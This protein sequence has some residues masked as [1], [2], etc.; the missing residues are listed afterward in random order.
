MADGVLQPVSPSSDREVF[1]FILSSGLPSDVTEALV[2]KR[3]F[4]ASLL[5]AARA[6]SAPFGKVRFFS[7][8]LATAAESKSSL[9]FADFRGGDADTLRFPARLLRCAAALAVRARASSRLFVFRCLT[10]CV[11]CLFS[12]NSTLPCANDE[13]WRESWAG[14]AEVEDKRTWPGTGAGLVRQLIDKRS[15]VPLECILF[16]NDWELLLLGLIS[17][18]WKMAFCPWEARRTVGLRAADVL[19]SGGFTGQVLPSDPELSSIDTA[20][21]FFKPLQSSK[22]QFSLRSDI[23]RLATSRAE[24]P[25]TF[26]LEFS[27]LTTA[28]NRARMPRSSSPFDSTAPALSAPTGFEC[29]SV[30]CVASHAR[31]ASSGDA[32]LDFP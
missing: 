19:Q 7:E 20:G 26:L 24:K 17:R 13:N 12:P 8:T 6:R 16:P 11:T 32:T 18:L 31:A 10:L 28:G 14:R 21:D 22:S 25:F 27:T 3:C 2:D 5:T 15:A 29:S 1:F 9:R 30:W 4:A 23:S